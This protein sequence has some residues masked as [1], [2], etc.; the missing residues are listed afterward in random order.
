MKSGKESG[1]LE[2]LEPAD[3]SVTGPLQEHLLHSEEETE[4]VGA[5]AVERYAWDN[6]Q[7]V[8]VDRS[9]PKPVRL[10]WS[11]IRRGLR[12]GVYRVTLSTSPGLDVDPIV[13]DDVSKTSADIWH[14]YLG[15]TYYW[16][17]VA[18]IGGKDVAESPTWSFTTNSI[19]PRWIKIPGITN[20]RDIGG[21]PLRDGGRIRQGMVYR[22]SEL[23]GNLQITER[24]KRILMDDLKIRTDLDLRG[25]FDTP[26]VALD[27]ERVH[28]IN[29][30]I[31]PYD[32]ITDA[33][34]RDAYRE[35]FEV[36]ANADNYPVL[37]HCVGGADRG[38]T[39]AFL[40]NGLLGKSREHLMRDFELTTLSVW[41]ERS[42][43]SEQFMAMMDVLRP[44][45]NGE[46]DPTV[47][48]ENYARSIG[49]SDDAI[50]R[51]REL[52]I[53]HE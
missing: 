53:E 6:L 51:I 2:L 16:K 41:G 15:R 25:A 18:Q 24:G 21:W 23:N 28:W 30:P 4:P 35:I 36:F 5:G 19:P 26:G 33:A 31:S 37:F 14:L 43:N 40:L 52:L 9:L 32:C 11:K 13:V 38:G 10:A 49:V 20:V 44:F 3:A 29:A 27:P 1:V 50:S 45:G 8:S 48:V 42:R 39:V 7:M 47:E 34:F 22:S 17:V 46:E 12:S